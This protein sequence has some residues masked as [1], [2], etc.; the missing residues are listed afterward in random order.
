MKQVAP[1]TQLKKSSDEG[2]TFS[3]MMGMMMMN[4]QQE[5]EAACKN[6]HS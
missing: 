3:N 5:Q 6:I 1:P 4:Q 2:F